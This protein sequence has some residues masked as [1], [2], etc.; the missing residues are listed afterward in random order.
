M[1]NNLFVF[2]SAIAVTAVF[3][4][5][6]GPTPEEQLIKTYEYRRQ[7]V[8]N[9]TDNLV[10]NIG[11]TYTEKDAVM[12]IL[13]DFVRKHFTVKEVT[14]ASLPLPRDP[15]CVSMTEVERASPKPLGK[16]TEKKKYSDSK[17][18]HWYRLFLRKKIAFWYRPTSREG[19][20]LISFIY[21]VLDK[22]NPVVMLYVLKIDFSRDDN[23]VLFWNVHKEIYDLKLTKQEEEYME[24]YFKYKESIEKQED[25]KIFMEKQKKAEEYYQYKHK[26]LKNATE[27]LDKKIQIFDQ[28]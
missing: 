26:E 1:K 9:Q 7:A 20:D 5:C 22:S 21:P 12:E 6:G 13:D 8:Y 25:M 10:D 23:P 16:Y 19:R 14:L 11:D 17:E 4:G 28:D 27:K 2:L 15:L 3:C 24:K 18:M